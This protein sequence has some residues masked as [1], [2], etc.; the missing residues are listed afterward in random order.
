VQQV[1]YDEPNPLVPQQAN[2]T[3]PAAEELS[4]PL[5]ALAQEGL[6]GETYPL[7]L[8]TALG[9]AGA[10]N[11]QIAFAAERVQQAFARMDQADLIWV[12]SINAGL[13]YNNHAG[14]IQA[15]E[16]SVIEV[17]RS[18][19]FVG[20]GAVTASSPLTGSS[21][22]PA[23][24]FVDLSLVDVF[25]EPLSARQA[26]RAAEATEATTFNDTLLQVA[27]AYLEL[28]RAHSQVAIANET[29]DNAA[30]LAKITADFAREGAGLEADA[31]RLRAELNGRHRELLQA[32]ELVAVASAELV[33]LLRLDP[34]VILIPADEHVVPIDVVENDT[35][36]RDL[37]SMAQ[38]VRPEAN[39]AYAA[40]DEAWLRARQER[41]R[42]W[43]PNVFA[44]FSGGGFGGGP[45]GSVSSFS[46]RTDFD[47]GA[48]W[49]LQNF[50]L[51]N[52]A[53]WR[54]QQSVHLQ[55]HLAADQTL[56]L[57]ASEVS[58]AYHQVQLRR[59][60]IDIT[61]LQVSSALR[62]LQLN[63]DGIR[64]R[65]L[66]AIEAQQAISALAAARSQ[67][68]DSIVSSNQA[69]YELLRA[70]GQP[71]YAD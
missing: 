29:V 70:I 26:V 56:D 37:I 44:G 42:P 71:V 4:A 62:A 47:L 43:L 63:L 49:E 22:G 66:R 21:G 54:E 20:G 12:P 28:L 45:G 36:L 6:E 18:S 58:R 64:G 2:E 10:N 50:G 57:I 30:K 34:A 23:R 69:Q 15:T 25:F 13:I 46:D 39:R 1:A 32:K 61:R 65:T 35:P 3:K 60:Q 53:R 33:R 38:N 52:A 41:I 5:P 7:D 67:Y 19:L 9:L 14:R 8:P 16:G 59:E 48:V 68:L 55:A 40:V 27:V 17:S 11:L 24:M 31:E 51:G